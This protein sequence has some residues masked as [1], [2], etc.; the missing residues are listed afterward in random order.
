MTASAAHIVAVID[1]MKADLEKDGGKP[2]HMYISRDIA[3]EIMDQCLDLKAH[4]LKPYQLTQFMGMKV[5][6]ERGVRPKSI[7]ICERE[8][9]DHRNG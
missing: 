4:G 9:E 3:E 6:I 5:H 8:I 2:G 7:L 1:K